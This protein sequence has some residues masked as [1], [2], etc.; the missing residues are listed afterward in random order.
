MAF[1]HYLLTIHLRRGAFRTSYENNAKLAY[2]TFARVQGSA[3]IRPRDVQ[4]VC[5]FG[6]G[7]GPYS[8]LPKEL[9]TA[10]RKRVDSG[11]GVFPRGNYL[12][13]VRL[14]NEILHL[15]RDV[16]TIV[17]DWN[18]LLLSNINGD[19]TCN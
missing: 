3:R 19:T 5:E 18:V 2:K 10:G 4:A 13:R 1:A 7:S 14:R 8:I 12:T 9:R 16:F 15:L 6:R 17:I 11:W